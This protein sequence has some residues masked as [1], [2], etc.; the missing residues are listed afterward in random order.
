MNAFVNQLLRYKT[1]L[2]TLQMPL[3]LV[4]VFYNGRPWPVVYI[5]FVQTTHQIQVLTEPL[6]R[7]QAIF[8]ALPSNERGNKYRGLT[9]SAKQNVRESVGLPIALGKL[10]CEFD[11]HL[12]F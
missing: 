8:L 4:Y 10:V 12:F 2:R 5:N 11:F 1:M 7:A 6:C 3:V 9:Y